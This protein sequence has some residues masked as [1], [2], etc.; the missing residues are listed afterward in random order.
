MISKISTLLCILFISF[1]VSWCTSSPEEQTQSPIVTTVPQ[2]IQQRIFVL[3]DSLSA[4]Y[5]LPYEDS[6]PAQLERLLRN[7]WNNIKV[8]NGWESGDTSEWLVSRIWWITADAQSGDIALIVIGG[9]DGLQ[10]R[11][12]QALADNI[13]KIVSDLQSRNIKTIIW[14]MQ[15]PTNLGEEYRTAFAQVYPQIAQETNSILIP[16]I[17]SWVAGIPEL[18]LRD[19]IHPNTTGQAIV[20]QTVYDVVINSLNMKK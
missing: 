2:T 18:N 17:L 7:N 1:L 8:I 11:S 19:G 9:N 4:G 3:W 6:Y 16:F 15:I 10:W 5:Q 12:T 14:G 20:A 13:K